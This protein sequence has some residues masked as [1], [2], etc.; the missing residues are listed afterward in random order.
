M[1][2]SR[3]FSGRDV[4][5]FA[6]DWDSDP[7]SRTHMMRLVARNNRVLWINSIGYR[8]MT[9]SKRDLTRVADKVKKFVEPVREVEP[10][11]F[12]L[13]PLAVPLYDVPAVQRALTDGGARLLEYR[14]E[15]EG[16]RIEIA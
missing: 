1:R 15:T 3:G 14:I 13:G 12:V 8:R 5:C 10:N 16:L 9:L 7:L 4:L 6:H 11:L 2:R